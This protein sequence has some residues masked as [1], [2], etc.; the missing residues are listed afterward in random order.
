MIEAILYLKENRNLWDIN[1]VCTA[2]IMLKENEKTARFEAR[3]AT[4][5]Q[6]QAQIMA[7]MG[8]LNLTRNDE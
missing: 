7:D 4:L 3:L 2:L 1:D 6:E 8:T 5:N